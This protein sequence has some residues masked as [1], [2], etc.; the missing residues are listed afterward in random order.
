MLESGMK[1]LY[2]NSESSWQQS[3]IIWQYTA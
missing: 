3:W 1:Q 2:K